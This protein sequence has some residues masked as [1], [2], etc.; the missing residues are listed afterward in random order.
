[1]ILIVNTFYCLELDKIDKG[2]SKGV[3]I[4]LKIFL[5]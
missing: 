3:R 5:D 1:M 4:I 2:I